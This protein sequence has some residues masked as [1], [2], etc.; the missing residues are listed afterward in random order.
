M[1][2]AKKDKNEQPDVENTEAQPVEVEGSD[3]RPDNEPADDRGEASRAED[4]PKRVANNGDVHDPGN[5]G[6]IGS[7]FEGSV[8]GRADKQNG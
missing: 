6:L 7:E 5:S 3:E 1:A 4:D 2:F 8:E